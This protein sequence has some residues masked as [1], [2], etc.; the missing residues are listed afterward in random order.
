M[1]ITF[2]AFSFLK[3]QLEKS[4]IVCGNSAMKL[5]ND[6]SIT[7]LIGHVGLEEKEVEA[8]FVNHKLMPKDTILK[9]GDRVALVPPGGIP[10]HVRAYV[11]DTK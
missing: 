9:D 4:G 6:I 11:G 1:T 2:N 3:A 5:D 8:I 10:N 7:E